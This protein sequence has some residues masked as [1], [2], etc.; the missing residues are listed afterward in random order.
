MAV[1]PG[2]GEFGQVLDQ[3]F[4]VLTCSCFLR[5]R[6]VDLQ[7]TVSVSVTKSGL[8]HHQK[9]RDGKRCG[10][11]ADL[12]SVPAELSQQIRAG[13]LGCARRRRSTGFRAGHRFRPI[14]ARCAVLRMCP[15]DTVGPAGLRHHGR[16]GQGWNSALS[17][18]PP[19]RKRI[20]RAAPGVELL[21]AQEQRWAAGW[22]GPGSPCSRQWHSR[23]SCQKPLERGLRSPCSTTVASLPR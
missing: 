20:R 4:D 10:S 21:G 22:G 11:D 17:E 15:A 14:T 23:V 13:G 12:P 9:P 2:A 18:H 5:L 19:P 3:R 6:V 16:I 7:Q 8:L 1:P